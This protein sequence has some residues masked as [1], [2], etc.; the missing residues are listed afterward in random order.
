M[1]VVNPGSNPTLFQC[2]VFSQEFLL[3]LFEAFSE[4]HQVRPSCPVLLLF[5][6]FPKGQTWLI[7]WRLF[8]PSST[9]A[10]APLY[11][12][13]ILTT[14]LHEHPTE[15]ELTFLATKNKLYKIPL[16]P[17]EIFHRGAEIKV[18]AEYYPWSFY[19]NLVCRGWI[20][21]PC[22][23]PPKKKYVPSSNPWNL[24]RCPYLGNESLQM[25]LKKISRWVH[26][27]FS[28]L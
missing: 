4:L 13:Q 23:P 7:V 24:W 26:P 25:S 14:F 28:G 3:G 1:V 18:L 6:S 27:K 15:S 5:V 11:P 8:P 9:P 22:P 19:L 21:A 10:P 17:L 20:A 16:R 12:S 2:P